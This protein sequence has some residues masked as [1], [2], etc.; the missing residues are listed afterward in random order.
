MSLFVSEKMYV[1]AYVIYNMYFIYNMLFYVLNY[2]CFTCVYTHMRH[3]HTHTHTH[4]YIYIY[5]Y[6]YT[7]TERDWKDIHQN[8]IIDYFWVVGL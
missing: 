8:A 4:I 1:F 3:T 2:I 5:I 6:T 7:Y